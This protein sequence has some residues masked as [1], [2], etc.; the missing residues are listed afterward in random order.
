MIKEVTLENNGYIYDMKTFVDNLLDKYDNSSHKEYL[1]K[2]K[3]VGFYR[4][5][6]FKQDFVS[7]TKDIYYPKPI[8]FSELEYFIVTKV[9]TP[10][11]MES[12]DEVNDFCKEEINNLLENFNK[13]LTLIKKLTIIG[14]KRITI[15]HE[16]FLIW[17]EFAKNVEQLQQMEGIL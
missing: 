1:L 15:D 3:D 9:Y 11:R 7:D 8:L 16:D 2:W 17:Q 10:T 13:G 12:Y 5:D 4:F 14:V 6:A